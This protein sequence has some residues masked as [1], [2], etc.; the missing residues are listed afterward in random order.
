MEFQE[1]WKECSRMCRNRAC[2]ECPISEM[3]I[4]QE[5]C[6]CWIGRNP[7]KSEEIINK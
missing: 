1:F 4:V 6:F 5:D 3:K 7:L 2:A